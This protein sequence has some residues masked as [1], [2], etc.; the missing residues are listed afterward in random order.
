MKQSVRAGSPRA[1]VQTVSPAVATSS[2]LVEML[3]AQTILASST[4]NL[5]A[6]KRE[7]D[8]LLR[9]AGT[10]QINKA[11]ELAGASKGEPFV[12][13]VAGP[14]APSLAKK[15]SAE[16]S[17]L[18]PGDLSEKELLKVERAALLNALR[19]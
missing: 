3:T 15:L 8:L 17:P 6:Q 10:T 7:M 11:I 1:L 12:L 2:T 18:P 5:L 19:A 9:F 16:S 14:I 4:G 13:V